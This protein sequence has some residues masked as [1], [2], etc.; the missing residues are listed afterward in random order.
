LFLSCTQPDPPETKKASFVLKEACK[1]GRIVWS[2]EPPPSLWEAY[3]VQGNIRV[4]ADLDYRNGFQY[5]CN[6]SDSGTLEIFYQ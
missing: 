1:D 4:T 3:Y 6:T 2:P 5:P